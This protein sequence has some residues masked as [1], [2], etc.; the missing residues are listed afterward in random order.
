MGGCV[1]GGEVSMLMVKGRDGQQTGFCSK[2][3]DGRV[4]KRPG[5]KWGVIEMQQHEGAVTAAVSIPQ[6]PGHL[7]SNCNESTCETQGCFRKKQ[8]RTTD[9]L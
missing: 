7:T 6:T 4:Q 3:K 1:W 2:T 5:T 9:A 8:V